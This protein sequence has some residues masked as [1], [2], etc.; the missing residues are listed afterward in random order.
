MPDAV[1]V[2]GACSPEVVR[3]LQAVLER[4][5]GAGAP[6]PTW[7]AA[8]AA[9]D[10]W[11]EHARR[12]SP[13]DRA[14][15]VVAAADDRDLARAVRMGFGGATLLPPS[16]P[17]VD[18]ACRAA[19]TAEA[20]PTADLELVAEAVADPAGAARVGW[21][22]RPV[23]ADVLGCRR[24][25]RALLR[26]AGVLGTPPIL[27]TDPELLVVG[28][29][30]AAVAQAWPEIAAGDLEV[31]GEPPRV[32]PEGGPGPPAR[33]VPRPRPVY[34]L[35]RGRRLGSWWIE[36]LGAEG[37]G[38]LAVPG[39]A[40]GGPWKLMAASA[41]E[42]IGVASSPSVVA[43]SSRPVL[44]VPGWMSADLRPGSPSAV[45]LERL[46]VEAGRTGTVLWVP[47]VDAD[48]LA[49]ALRLG[50]PLWVDGPAVPS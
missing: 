16:T 36:P 47:G 42:E 28:L 18:A 37:E 45:L 11:L 23:W 20:L 49:V 43:G 14:R 39:A 3:P 33:L 15:A 7:V 30:A 4:V 19:A 12:A 40:P 17:G 27:T 41:V 50:V 35:P 9:E 6:Q 10:G 48:G 2:V 1:P 21:R 31:P 34:E 5:L 8:G 32:T 38:W 25:T 13:V 24:L 46:A 26:L 29:D 22:S 44:R